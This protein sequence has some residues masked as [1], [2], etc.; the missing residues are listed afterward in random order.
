VFKLY[1]DELKFQ[2]IIARWS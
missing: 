2:L 1:A